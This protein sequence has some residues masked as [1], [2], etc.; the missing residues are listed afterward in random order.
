METD[1]GKKL[2]SWASASAL[3]MA[4]GI[5]ATGGDAYAQ[6]SNEALKQQVD[7]LT[8]QLEQVRTQL[9]NVVKHLAVPPAAPVPLDS[10]NTQTHEFLERKPGDGLTFVTRGGEISI[11][12][13]LDLSVDEM[14]KGLGGMTVDGAPP[15]GRVGWMPD[16]STNLSYVGVRGF[17]ALGGFPASFVYQLET[18]IDISAASGTSA[19]NSN[20][21]AVV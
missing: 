8:K 5:F 6:S 7:Q 10:P 2:K 3:A 12:G 19:S 17:Q 9:D 14:T 21:S 11:Y 1:M 15:A 13:N 4:T 20:S 18:Q 16:L